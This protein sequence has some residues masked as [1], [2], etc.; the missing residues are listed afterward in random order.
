M[1]WGGIRKIRK[2]AVRITREVVSITGGTKTKKLR[3]RIAKQG[4]VPSVQ[5]RGGW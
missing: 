4:T 5:Y 1:E 2:G 3:M